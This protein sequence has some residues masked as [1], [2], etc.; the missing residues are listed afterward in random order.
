MLGEPSNTPRPV[1]EKQVELLFER[2][3]TP[4]GLPWVGDRARCR[5][6]RGGGGCHLPT[7][8]GE[9]ARASTSY[10]SPAEVPL[11]IGKCTVA[12]LTK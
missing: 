3:D 11:A 9:R 4:G 1:R 8:P 7:N 6:G 2:Y 5:A 12:L 10:S